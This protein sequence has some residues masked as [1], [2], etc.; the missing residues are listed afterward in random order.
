MVALALLLFGSTAGGLRGAHGSA[1]DLVVSSLGI[2]TVLALLAVAGALLSAK[3]L[4]ERLG[5]GAS[6][7]DAGSL[8]LL[9]LGTLALSHGLDAAVDVLS[10]R[11][12]SAL[13]DLA[14]RLD[15]VRGGTLALAALAVGVAPGLAEELLCRGLL[16]RGL[17]ARLGPAAGIALAALCFGALHIEPVHGTVAV[18]LGLYLGVAAHWADSTRASMLCHVANNL[19]ALSAL[20]LGVAG[21]PAPR[22]SLVVGLGVAGGCLWLV[23]ARRAVARP[24]PPSPAPSFEPD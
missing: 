19:F 13:E 15:G 5:L 7:L 23:R 4:V 11:P 3:P 12:G 2:E 22:V 9:G 1:L 21:Q 24:L 8:A 18:G 10:L 6:R 14:L 20:A 16:Q 17:A